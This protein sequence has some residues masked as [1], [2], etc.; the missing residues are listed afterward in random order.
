MGIRGL[1]ALI[2]KYSPDCITYNDI[3]KYYGK[4]VAIDCSILLY[5][6]KYASKV[7]NSHL[8]GIANRVKFYVMNGILPVF[9]FD[10]VPPD[11]KSVTLEKRHA[12]KEKI[13][14]RLEELREKV[15]ENFQ[16]KKDISDEIEKLQS[17]IIVVKKYH[18]EQCKEFLEKSGI[19]YCTAPSD[20]E[21]YCAFLQRNNLVDYTITDDSDALTFGCSTV[22][23]TS[24]S[25]QITEINLEK[26]LSDI[27]MNMDNFVDY[28]ILSGCDYTES[29]PLIGP[30]TAYNLIKKHKCIENIITNENKIPENF[31]F[32]ICRDIFTTFDYGIPEPFCIKRINKQVL[33]DFMN[34]H[35]FR[36]NVICKFIK[37]LI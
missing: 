36:D 24:I 34:E 6:F 21:K 30:V 7:E 9:I 3:K 19:P 31:N 22:L 29:I 27:D 4:I 33:I 8:I 18:V 1:N 14:L 11:A 17:Q 25:K 5:K 10:G 28:C 20:A 12:A 26:L 37:I 13:Y 35:N 15:P 23:K 32:N 2:K 16:E